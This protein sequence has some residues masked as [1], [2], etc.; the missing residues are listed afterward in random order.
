MR[1]CNRSLLTLLFAGTLSL[2]AAP[3][4]AVQDG[5]HH[6]GEGGPA[7]LSLDDGAKWKTD[8]T[9]RRGMQNIRDMLEPQLQAIHNDRLKPAQYAELARRIEAEVAG[10][11][12]GCK[13]DRDADAMLHL[14]L[15]EINA[16]T[17][18]LAGRNRALG[19]HGGAVTIYRALQNYPV[20]FEHPGW[21]TISH[22]E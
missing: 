15:A 10:I 1:H 12:A 5:H 9:L 3:A 13:L 7:A 22:K 8:A 11:V 17:E 2:V 21:R 20:Y 6:H 14:V 18:G 19:R 4:L 16:G